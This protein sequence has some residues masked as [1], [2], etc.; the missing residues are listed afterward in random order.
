MSLDQHEADISKVHGRLGKRLSAL[1]E[2]HKR[3][4][5]AAFHLD[6]KLKSDAALLDEFKKDPI[7]V[8]KREGMTVSEGFH[9][10]FVNEKNEY[11]PPENDAISQLQAGKKTPIWGRLEIRY[12]VGPG[13]VVECGSCDNN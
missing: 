2:D 8:A 1:Q 13:C 10:H 3:N 4:D 11:F 6:R 7:A 12:A 5:K 9:L